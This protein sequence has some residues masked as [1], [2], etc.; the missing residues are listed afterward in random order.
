VG[1][2][3]EIAS[4]TKLKRTASMSVTICSASAISAV[5]RKR[6]PPVNSTTS[7]ADESKRAKARALRASISGRLE[8]NTLEMLIGQPPRQAIVGHLRF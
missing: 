8:K 5:L 1:G 6:I 7:I 2:R 4:A 3:E